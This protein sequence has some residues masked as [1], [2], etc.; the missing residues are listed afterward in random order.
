M[1]CQLAVSATPVR[2]APN[3]AYRRGDAGKRAVTR[4]VT[5]VGSLGFDLGGTDGDKLRPEAEAQGLVED[6]ASVLFATE[7]LRGP[8]AQAYLGLL[9]QIALK[10]SPTRLFTAYGAFFRAQSTTGAASFSDHVIDEIITGANNPLA[11]LCALGGRPP[12]AIELNAAKADLDLLQNLCV[13]ETTVL[14]WC[15]KL[16]ANATPRRKQPASWILAAETLGGGGERS[17]ESDDNSSTDDE[18][19]PATL[20]QPI[21]APARPSARTLLREQ[22][23]NAWAWSDSLPALMTHWTNV[24]TGEVGARSVLRWTGLKTGFKGAGVGEELGSDAYLGRYG[25]DDD[26]YVVQSIVGAGTAWTAV[27]ADF[28]SRPSTEKAR[29][30]ILAELTKEKPAHVLL[31]GPPGVG[32]RFAM[33]SAIGETFGA[34]VRCVQ[35]HRG[36]LRSLAEILCEI[37][38]HPRVKFVLFLEMPLCLTPYAEFHNELVGAMDGGGGGSWPSHAVLCATAVKPTGLKPG[39]EDDGADGTS[40]SGRFGVIVA[41]ETE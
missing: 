1:L 30:A 18:W 38:K 28:K 17:K 3:R 9:T 16:A 33:R 21:A 25:E 27:E 24:G 6:A 23:A 4:P 8:V 19:K 40:L 15:E 34:G 13:S 10:A 32:K 41:M 7:C 35:M 14:R 22:V 26:D 39:G 29:A 31:H 5:R 36:D 20:A 2:V 11:E 12:T 37:A